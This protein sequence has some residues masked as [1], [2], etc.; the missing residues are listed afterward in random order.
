METP[1]IPR[2]TDWKALERL[3]VRL[4]RKLLRD[5]HA[6]LYGTQGQRQHGLDVVARD[7]RPD[8][9]GK[10]W[11]FQSKNYL[12]K[13]LRPS[14]LDELVSL[15]QGYQHWKSIDT[16]VVVTTANV[17]T[18]VHDKAV[19]LS[20]Q[21]QLDFHVWDWKDFSDLLREHCGMGP[22]LSQEE[23]VALRD[24]YC[25]WA[26][27]ELRQAGPLYPLHLLT[28]EQRDVRLEEVL[29]PRTLRA[30]PQGREVRARAAAAGS[31]EA[32]GGEAQPMASSGEPSESGRVTPERYEGTL[33]EWLQPQDSPGKPLLLMLAPMG[34][35]KTVAFLQAEAQLAAVARRELEAPLPLRLRAAELADGAVEEL[36]NRRGFPEFERL[37][38]DPPCEWVVLVD[39]LDEVDGR[40]QR[41]VVRALLAL[42]TANNVV[43]VAVSCR[44]SHDNPRLLSDAQRVELPPWSDDESTAFLRR[45]AQAPQGGVPHEKARALLASDPSLRANALCTTLLI[46]RAT[47]EDA[48]QAGRAWLFRP[49][50]DDLFRAWAKER[51]IGGWEELQHSLERLALQGLEQGRFPLSR[52]TLETA[53]ARALGDDTGVA[54]AL[55]AARKLGLVRLTEGGTWDM[56]LRAI[57]EYL[58]AGAL[59]EV[60]DEAFTRACGQPWAGEV[61]RLAVDRRWHLAPERTQVLLRGLLKQQEGD[62]DEHLLRRTLVVLQVMRDLG[63]GVEDVPELPVHLRRSLSDES[64]DWRRRRLGEAVRELAREGGPLWE[65]VCLELEPLLLSQGNRATWLTRYE[66]DDVNFWLARLLEYDLEVRVAAIQKLARWKHLPEVLE[67]LL[68]QLLDGS[69][70]LSPNGHGEPALTAA[71]VLRTVP[72]TE[73]LLAT[74]RAHL[75]GVNEHV[76]GAAA[77]ALLPGEAETERLLSTLRRLYRRLGFLP[78]VLP[79][80]RAAIEAHRDVSE[81]RAWLECYWPEVLNPGLEDW[82]QHFTSYE[83]PGDAPTPPASQYVRRDLLWSIT[84]ALR[85][86]GLLRKVEAGPF[87]RQSLAWLYCVLAETAP[88]PV[89]EW[90]R[91]EAQPLSWDAQEALGRAVLRWPPLARALVERWDKKSDALPVNFPGVALEPLA[92]RGEAEA[93]RVYSQWLPEVV[94]NIAPFPRR[95]SPTVLRQPAI[96]EAAR[97]AAAAAWSNAT[98]APSPLGELLHCLWPSWKDELEVTAG[99]LEWAR[100]EDLERVDAALRAWMQGGFPPEVTRSLYERLKHQ[101]AWPAGDS[102]FWEHRLPRWLAAAAHAAILPELEPVLRFL[103]ESPEPAGEHLPVRYQAC[104]YLLRLH[105]EEAVHLVQCAASVWPWHWGDNHELVLEDVRHLVSAAPEVWAEACLEALAQWGHQVAWDFLLMVGSL[106]EWLPA[107]SSWRQKLVAGIRELAGVRWRWAA[108]DFLG[109]YVRIDDEAKRLLFHLGESVDTAPSKP[110]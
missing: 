93:V 92:A 49:V 71:A 27:E 78:L 5:T 39:G 43:G 101:E 74:L 16:F 1:E 110:L 66:C 70:G 36:L 6:S 75:E 104:A 57:T 26:A 28:M 50:V 86:R 9:T 100:G 103:A 46:L 81:G 48:P 56:P 41:D 35:G 45:W 30:L 29:I 44:T 24:R 33:V 14:Q 84:P 7:R 54:R 67:A 73:E 109:P 64:S 20:E 106:C 95:V 88:E 2:P 12:A 31:G 102:F 38:A 85:G 82:F 96:H 3:I 53:L 11:A 76:A 89:V 55:E 17:S 65:A 59:R 91:D 47:E 58:A 97:T 40:A 77:V 51:G 10:L 4:A 108:V 42:H 87:A 52:R 15:L 68:A 90:L 63:L 98:L 23:R 18:E 25:C 107:L 72:R 80:V 61:A 13:M 105:P 8:G 94:D 62:S 99:L 19:E 83:N 37:W 22:W 21:L 32:H 69:H 79:L 60:D 34:A